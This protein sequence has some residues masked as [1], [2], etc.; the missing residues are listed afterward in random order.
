MTRESYSFE[1]PIYREGSQDDEG[2]PNAE[3]SGQSR[4]WGPEPEESQVLT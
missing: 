3:K 4:R 2:I 1:I